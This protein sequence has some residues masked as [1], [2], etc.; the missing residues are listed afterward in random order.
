MM[1]RGDDVVTTWIRHIYD[2]IRRDYSVDT[3]RLRCDTSWIR[4]VYD[5]D[6]TCT[7][8][9]YDVIRRGHNAATRC[10]RRETPWIRRRCDVCT[11][12][13]VMDTTCIRCGYDVDATCIRRATYW[14]R[15]G[16]AFIRRE[17]LAIA[18]DS[19]R[20]AIA[21]TVHKSVIYFKRMVCTG[22]AIAYQRS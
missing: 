6:T 22:H 18:R 1:L 14:M 13:Y 3:T 17:T 21:G 10:T 16:Y 11:M 12:W 2:V 19:T 4:H 9:V 5:V 8:C 15:H 20:Y 7:R